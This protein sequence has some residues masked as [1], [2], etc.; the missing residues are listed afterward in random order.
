MATCNFYKDEQGLFILKTKK[1]TKKNHP[2]SPVG[3]A[4]VQHL[5]CPS[6]QGAS[7][8]VKVGARVQTPRGPCTCSLMVLIPSGPRR[9]TA[10]FTRSVRPQFS[11]RKPRSCLNLASM[12]T[13]SSFREA[14]KQSSALR[15]GEM[16]SGVRWPRQGRAWKPP[17]LGGTGRLYIRGP[18][19]LPV[20][21][22][23]SGCGRLDPLSFARAV[24]LSCPLCA[25]TLGAKYTLGSYLQNV[26]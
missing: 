13:A 26:Y 9:D 22:L 23:S 10:C 20:P 5:L 8:V 24:G 12:A 18:C 1:I 14:K 2:K 7:L 25:F 21:G 15:E 16:V 6:G 17:G 3:G 4:S 11:I 19:P